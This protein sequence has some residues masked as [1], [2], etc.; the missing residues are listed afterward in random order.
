MENMLAILN[1]TVKQQSLSIQQQVT[2]NQ[3][4]ATTI[5]QQAASLQQHSTT[6]QQQASSIQQQA[7]TIQ[8]QRTEIRQLQST[9]ET[10]STYIIWGRKQCQNKTDTEQV[11]SGYA[12]GGM[13]DQSGSAADYVCLP[14]DPDFVKTSGYDGGHMY[15]AEYESN[16]FG[17]WNEDVPCAVCRKSRSTSILMIPGKNKCYKGW[18]IEYH[19]YLASGE[20]DHAAA[21]SYV[22]V[23]SQPEYLNGGVQNEN[24]K[25]FYPV[26]AKC[27][28]LQCPPYINDHPLT[29][30]V[31]S[32]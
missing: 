27:G 25:L 2:I 1:K 16:F 23:D 6:I 20:N 10:G 31:C 4:Q 26:L 12:G 19:G 13:Y 14:P 29:C 15:G 18:N 7:T 5:Q 28:A 3:Q 8:L 24:G 9:Q 17:T 32:K 21:S 11:Y 30:V 22:C